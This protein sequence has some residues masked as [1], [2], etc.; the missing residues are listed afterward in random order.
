MQKQNIGK[1][2][3]IEIELHA[4]VN[5]LSARAIINQVFVYWE[6]VKKDIL[7]K[8]DLKTGGP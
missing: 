8:Y 7:Q 2:T 4:F 5:L 3:L 1:A 6:N